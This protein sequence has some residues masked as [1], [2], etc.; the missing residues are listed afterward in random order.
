MSAFSYKLTT[1]SE[2]FAFSYANI[3]ASTETI[4]S[5]AL[6]VE[7]KD[8]SDSNPTAIVSGLPTINGAIVSQRILGG[9]DSVT[10]RLEMTATTSLGNVYTLVGDLPVLAPINS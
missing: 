4:V 7:V 8:G 3:L 1:E 2:K 9:L 5:A 10:Y 6:V